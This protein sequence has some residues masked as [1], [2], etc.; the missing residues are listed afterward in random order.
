[1]SQSAPD[2]L[3]IAAPNTIIPPVSGKAHVDEKV[4][5]GDSSS[6]EVAVVFEDGDVIKE[7]DYTDEEYKKLLKKI[8]R[9]LLPLMVR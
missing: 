4:T 9:F 7:S 3:S 5:L 8:D 6:E 1:M 2:P